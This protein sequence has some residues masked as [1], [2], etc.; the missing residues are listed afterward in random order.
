[1]SAIEL[2]RHAVQRCRQRGINDL[3]VALVSLFGDDHYQAGGCTFSF[4]PRRRLRA[5]RAALDRLEQVAL[6]KTPGEAV[7][8]VM[9]LDR[10]V[11]H[12]DFSS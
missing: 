11:R 12:T 5:L 2:T 3:Q 10:P 7:A 9:H 8:T 1:M 6:I 4:I